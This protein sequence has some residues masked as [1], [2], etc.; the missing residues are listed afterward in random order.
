[1]QADLADTED[2]I[3]ASRRIYN[4][5]VRELNTSLQSFPANLIA[6]QLGF[7]AAEFFEIERAVVH[8]VVDV[9]FPDRAR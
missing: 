8:A 7:A 6:R 9:S 2:R 3:Q 5:N 1:M 4:A